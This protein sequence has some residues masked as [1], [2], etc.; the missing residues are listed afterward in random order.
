MSGFDSGSIQT[1]V[2]AQA[3]Q[4]GSIL[5]G[6]GPP[7]PETGVLG[8]LYI[9]V[10]TWFLYARRDS[11]LTDPWGHYVFQV[12][13][14]Y[15]NTL[16]WYSSSTPTDD[17]GV[18]GDYALLWG[19]FT[20]YGAQMSVFGPKQSTTWRE[21]GN[22]LGTVSDPNYAGY[23]NPVGLQGEGTALAYSA[24]TQIIVAGLVDEYVLSVPSSLPAGTVINQIGLATGAAIVNVQLNPRYT[25]QDSHGI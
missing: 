5:R 1:G 13:L 25:A 2:S 21:N 24:S 20:N 3:K 16:K 10:Q 4:F 23:V 12:P 14:A 6:Y 11:R 9:D 17:I 7:V 8:D 22:G 18:S 19:G 15:R